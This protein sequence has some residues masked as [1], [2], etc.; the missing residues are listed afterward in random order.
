[1]ADKFDTRY[2]ILCFVHQAPG[3][4]CMSQSVENYTFRQKTTFRRRCNQLQAIG[5]RFMTWDVQKRAPVDVDD[6]DL[7]AIR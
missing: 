3:N 1:M 7:G 6:D 2:R 5:V 4:Q